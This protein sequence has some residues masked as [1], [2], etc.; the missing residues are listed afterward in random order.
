MHVARKGQKVFLRY[1]R[2]R[3]FS[4]GTSRFLEIEFLAH[5]DHKDVMRPAR[6]RGNEGLE[7][8]TRIYPDERRH[9]GA[10]H[11][12]LAVAVTVDIIRYLLRVQHSHRVS[13]VLHVS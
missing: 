6:A 10:L 9:L 7:Y 1:H 8:L 13:F 12:R 3:F 2:Y 5:G 11:R 4:Y